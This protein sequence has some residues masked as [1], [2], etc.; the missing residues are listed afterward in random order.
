MTAM[1]TRET[2]QILQRETRATVLQTWSSSWSLLLLLQL[3]LYLLLPGFAWLK[4][5]PLL[6]G[7]KLLFKVLL[8]LL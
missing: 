1:A 8:P 2:L 4:Y 6:L 3:L 5:S 7:W